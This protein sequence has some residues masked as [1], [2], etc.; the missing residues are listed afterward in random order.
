MAGEF[1]LREIPGASLSAQASERHGCVGFAFRRSLGQDLQELIGNCLIRH[2]RSV[3]SFSQE[4]E[5]MLKWLDRPTVLIVQRH[6]YWFAT[7][8]VQR[9]LEFPLPLSRLVLPP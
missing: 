1:V 7:L 4:G 2:G 9:Q 6:L 3:H 5:P 8:P